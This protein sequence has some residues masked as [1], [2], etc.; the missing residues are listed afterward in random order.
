MNKSWAGSL[1]L[2]RLWV[3]GACR[4]GGKDEG[5]LYYA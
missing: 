4:G 5:V 3:G 1:G 2:V